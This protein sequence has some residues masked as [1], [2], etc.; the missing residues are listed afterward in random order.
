MMRH[1]TS[2]LL[3]SGETRYYVQR[4]HESQAEFDGRVLCTIEETI[5]AGAPR[6]TPAG[7][8]WVEWWHYGHA[9]REFMSNGL[10]NLRESTGERYQHRTRLLPGLY[11]LKQARAALGLRGGR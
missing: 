5:L 11:D 8:R 7:T 4:A 2:V 10:G 6:P 1:M 9:V 3:P